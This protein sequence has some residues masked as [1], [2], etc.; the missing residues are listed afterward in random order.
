ML[1]AGAG[2]GQRVRV[3]REGQRAADV[4]AHKAA[5][6]DAA[7]AETLRRRCRRSRRAGCA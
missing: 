1:M 5:G 3:G 4:G 7:Q 6:A 2:T